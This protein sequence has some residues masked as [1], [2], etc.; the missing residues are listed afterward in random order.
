MKNEVKEI[1]NE[2]IHIFNQPLNKE[3]VDKLYKKM[4]SA[5]QFSAELFQSEDEYNQQKNH[6]KTN[7]CNTFNFL[8]QFSDDIQFIEENAAIKSLITELL[9]DDYEIVI[10]KLV[11]GVPK[12]SVPEWVKMKIDGV[13]VANLGPYIKKEYRDITYFRGIDFHQDIIDWPK[14]KT[15]LDPSTFLT[16]YVYI[17]DVGIYDSPLQVIPKSHKLGATLF[18]H[19]LKNL[20]SNLWS[21]QDDSGKKIDCEVKILTGSTG[22]TAL[23]HNC[24]LHGTQPVKHESEKFR[25]SLRYLIGKSNSNTQRTLIDEVNATINGDLQPI[26]TRRDLDSLGK[27]KIKKNII[28]ESTKN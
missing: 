10:K 14:G 6:F 8:N 24:T 4:I 2:G 16:L 12:S 18:P 28:N 5:R 26:R 15:D 9:G 3:N 20:T 11:C 19:K 22:Y 13:N 21:Y 25:I 23:W 1:L 7:P 17:H 27:A